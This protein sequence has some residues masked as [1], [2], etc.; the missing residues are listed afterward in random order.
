MTGLAWLLLSIAGVA[1]LADWW[2]VARTDKR[3]EYVTKPATLLALISVAIVLEP[4]NGSMR[5]WFV[6]ALAFSLAGDIFLMLP[7]NL[8]VQGLASFL[9]AHLAYV[10]GFVS[11]GLE[12]GVAIVAAVVV[13][14]AIVLYARVLIMGM[15][16]RQRSLRIP[17]SIYAAAIGSMLIAAIAS[18]SPLAIIGAALFVLSDGLIGFSRF[19][20]PERWAPLAIIVTYHLGQTG[21]VLSLA[22]D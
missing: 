4:S 3:V 7:G 10:A 11:G 12:S 8:F 13:G 5:A 6:L 18:E 16:E 17:V 15:T 1:A 19:V 9:V 22:F 2:A 14:V 21:L 20:R